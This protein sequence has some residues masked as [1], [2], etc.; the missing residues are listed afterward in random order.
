MGPAVKHD[1][2]RGGGVC[3]ERIQRIGH[4]TA[5]KRRA[6]HHFIVVHQ[7]FARLDAAGGKAHHGNGVQINAVCVRVVADETH[8]PRHVQRVGVVA[9]ELIRAAR[10]Q[11]HSP[12]GLHTLAH[13]NRRHIGEEI[14]AVKAACH[15]L[16]K[17]RDGGRV[18]LLSEVKDLKDAR[19]HLCVQDGRAVLRL[20]QM[21]E[22][23]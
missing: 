1:P 23:A 7:E 3:R 8:S 15:A 11:H 5:V 14:P 19:I 18:A 20:R 16:G 9:P 21:P 17:A 6:F 22:V 10:H 2:P 4:I 12:L 13:G